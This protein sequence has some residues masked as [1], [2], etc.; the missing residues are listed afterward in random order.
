[1]TLFSRGFRTPSKLF[2]ILSSIE[3]TPQSLICNLDTYE[4]EQ[5]SE[6]SCPNRGIETSL[7][8]PGGVTLRLEGVSEMTILIVIVVLILLFGGGGY[9]YRRWRT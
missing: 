7:C 3:Q 5:Q 8:W 4:Y 1:V 6:A 2:S 9:G